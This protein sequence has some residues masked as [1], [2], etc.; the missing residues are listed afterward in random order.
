MIYL[1]PLINYSL[2]RAVTHVAAQWLAHS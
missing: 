2:I 1:F